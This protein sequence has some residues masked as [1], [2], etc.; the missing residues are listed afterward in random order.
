M[1]NM[2]SIA[3]FCLAIITMCILIVFAISY[4]Q[5]AKGEQA[6]GGNDEL[7]ELRNW[8]KNFNEHHLGDNELNTRNSEIPTN[9]Y[10]SLSAGNITSNLSSVLKN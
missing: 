4:V 1:I 5:M 3:I 8:L 7:T 6:S 2:R 10:N 9:R